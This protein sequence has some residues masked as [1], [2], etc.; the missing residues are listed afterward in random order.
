MKSRHCASSQAARRSRSIGPSSRRRRTPDRRRSARRTPSGGFASCSWI[1][2]PNASSNSRSDC[3]FGQHRE[4]R[5]DARLDRPLAQQ[6]GAEAVDGADVRFLERLQRLVQACRA[7]RRSGAP[8]RALAFERFAQPQLQLAGRLLGE[9]DRDDLA[10]LGAAVARIRTMR[11]TSSVVLPVPAAASTTSVSSSAVG[12]DARAL[13]SR[14]RACVAVV[15]ASPAAAVEIA[16]LVRRLARDALLL[17]GTADRPEVA[18]GARPLGRRGRQEAKLDRAIDDLERLEPGAA[19][20][21]DERDLV[22]GEPAGR[23]AVEQP[24]AATPV[25]SRTCSTARL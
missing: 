7:A 23:G 4:Q 15:M 6:V 18:P 16:E 5:I 13:P 25:G 12:D 14:C 2:A 17:V 21:I 10:D 19:V 9:R 1:H 8:A 24:S 22:L 3:R 11:S 20:G